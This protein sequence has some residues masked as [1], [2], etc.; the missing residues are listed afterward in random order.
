MSRRSQAVATLAV[1]VAVFALA[2]VV[3]T[4]TAAAD[5]PDP[6]CAGGG[7]GALYIPNSSFVASE[8]ASVTYGTFLNDSTTRFGNVTI[9]GNGTGWVTL[10]DVKATMAD[11]DGSETCYGNVTA[12]VTP[13][14][15]AVDKRNNVTVDGVLDSLS[16]ATV[17][18][19]V[20]PAPARFRASRPSPSDRATDASVSLL[21]G[22]PIVRISYPSVARAATDG[23]CPPPSLS[24]RTSAVEQASAVSKAFAQ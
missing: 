3:L 22:Q 16:L 13:L 24:S 20:C 7:E 15:V 18:S 1:A 9:T 11:P 14:T 8:N 19:R 2:G 10:E 12:D 23:A 6:T 17:A 4:G 21:T 5:P